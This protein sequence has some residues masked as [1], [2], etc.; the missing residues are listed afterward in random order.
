MEE[1]K[2]NPPFKT[3]DYVEAGKYLCEKC[4]ANHA[5]DDAYIISR[6]ES[7]RLPKCEFCGET[8]WTRL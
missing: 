3:G 7:F 1:L 8:T 4:Y 5:T 6:N 2:K